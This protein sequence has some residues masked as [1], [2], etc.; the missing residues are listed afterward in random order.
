MDY[1]KKKSKNDYNNKLKN[2]FNFLSISGKYKIIGSASLK[3]I[4]YASDYD[5]NE[6]YTSNANNTYNKVYQIFREKFISAKMNPNI[7]IIDFKCGEV[8]GEPIRWNYKDMLKGRKI[9]SDGSRISFQDCLKMKSTI[10]L[11]IIAKVNSVFLDITEN[12]FLKLGSNTNFDSDFFNKENN[13]KS[14]KQSFDECILEKD[15]FKALKRSFSY[16]ALKNKTKYKS[17]LIK[18][19]E[20]FNSAV[21]IINKA[22]NDLNTLIF[23]IENKFRKP[24]IKDIKSNLQIIKQSLSVEPINKT[25]DNMCNLKSLTSILFKIKKLKDIL[26]S[27]SNK[28]TLDF[29]QKNKNLLI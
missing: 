24:N 6:E 9:L 23:L 15:F 10:K 21:G 12:Y 13:L 28:T 3:S 5:L 17:Q 2:V 18:L 20:F 11:D 26:Y 27:L 22:K 14:I 16:K 19:V 1:L 8:D 25:I 29:I 4:L 7:Y